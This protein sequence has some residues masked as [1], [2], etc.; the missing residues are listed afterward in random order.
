SSRDRGKSWRAACRLK[1]R[2][3]W[4]ASLAARG[5][6]HPRAFSGDV[7]KSGLQDREWAEMHCE[8][9]QEPSQQ[10]RA[11]GQEAK[12][13]LEGPLE[14]W[15]GPCTEHRPHH[16]AQVEAGRVNQQTFQD[17]R[18]PPEVGASHAAGLVQVREGTFDQLASHPV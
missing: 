15:R 10:G 6:S 13:R 16:E 7:L 9:V 14:A 12:K 3:A 2:I 18:V 4:S 8:L 5:E 1:V 11:V 17:V